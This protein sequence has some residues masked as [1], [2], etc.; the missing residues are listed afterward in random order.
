VIGAVSEQLA[1]AFDFNDAIR[2][3]ARDAGEDESGRLVLRVVPF[4][5]AVVDLAGE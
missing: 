2:A 1:V 4:G 3:G 5:L